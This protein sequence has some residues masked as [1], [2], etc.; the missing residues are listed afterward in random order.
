MMLVPTIMFAAGPLRL[1]PMFEGDQLVEVA[2]PDCS[3]LGK[4]EG[5]KCNRCSGQGMVPGIA[6][7]PHRPVQVVGTVLSGD[8]KIVGAEVKVDLGSEGELTYQTN[9]DGQ[10]GVK[11]PPGTYQIAVIHEQNSSNQ[12]V[13]VLHHKEPVVIEEGGNLHRQEVE[14]QL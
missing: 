2:C 9:G 11:L 14:F 13:V 1:P 6:A 5:E 3:G 4:V 8:N 12:Q 7:G 10:F